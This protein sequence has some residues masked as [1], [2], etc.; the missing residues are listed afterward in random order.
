MLGPGASCTTLSALETPPF[1]LAQKQLLPSPTTPSTYNAPSRRHGENV[2]LRWNLI[3]TINGWNTAEC[4]SSQFNRKFNTLCVDL[5]GKS[6][7]TSYGLTSNWQSSS[8]HS[9]FFQVWYIEKGR[10]SKKEKKRKRNWKKI[11]PLRMFCSLSLIN[12]IGYCEKE[13]WFTKKYGLLVP[14]NGLVTWTSPGCVPA[15]WPM[16]AGVDT[17]VTLS[18]SKCVGWC[19]DGFFLGFIC[20]TCLPMQMY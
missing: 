8:Q 12:D 2:D 13:T 6:R 7:I 3:F 16:H 15:S 20:Q 17:P 1:T 14:C 5:N 11:P 18:R 9:W 10:S 19:M 4:R